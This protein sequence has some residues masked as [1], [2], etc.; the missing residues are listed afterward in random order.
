[1]TS[2]LS[3]VACQAPTLLKPQTLRQVVGY[4]CNLTPGLLSS[5]SFPLPWLICYKQARMDLSSIWRNTLKS[6]KPA[7]HSS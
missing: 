5:G 6:T 3:G 2:Q 1:M 4:S 7:E